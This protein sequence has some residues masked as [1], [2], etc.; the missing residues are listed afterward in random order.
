M[1]FVKGVWLNF[2]RRVVS[3]VIGVHVKNQLNSLLKSHFSRPLKNAILGFSGTSPGFLAKNRPFQ[4]VGGQKFFQKFYFSKFR[5][6]PDSSMSEDH[7]KG[8][9]CHLS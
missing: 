5:F 6:A 3:Q 1:V 8:L 9:L 7:F 4:Q 2:Y